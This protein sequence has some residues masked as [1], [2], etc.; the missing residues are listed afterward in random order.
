MLVFQSELTLKK[1]DTTYLSW[2]VDFVTIVARVDVI[3]F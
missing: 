2:V 1:N 3:L